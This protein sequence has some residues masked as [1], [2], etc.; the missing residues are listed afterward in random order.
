MDIGADTWT[1]GFGGAADPFT[2]NAEPSTAALS[3][4]GLLGLASRR[5]RH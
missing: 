2:L 1:W 3:A 4:L 5:R